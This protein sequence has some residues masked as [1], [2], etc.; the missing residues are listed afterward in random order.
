MNYLTVWDKNTEHFV[1]RY[2]L[3]IDLD[4]LNR[5]LD[6][7]PEIDVFGFDVPDSL[8][9]EVGKHAEAPVIMDESRFYQVAFF[10]A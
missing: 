4:D 1:C 6:I 10:E 7:D 3:D 8:V 5:I 2:R 9:S